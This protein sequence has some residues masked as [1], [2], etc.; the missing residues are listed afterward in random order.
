M[1][2]RESQGSGE[3][4]RRQI[5]LEQ[6]HGDERIEEAARRAWSQK[7]DVERALAAALGG[8]PEIKAAEK[9][10]YLGTFEERVVAFY[11]LDE[12]KEPGFF[13]R[14]KSDLQDPRAYRLRISAE[15]DMPKAIKYIQAA[16]ALGLKFDRVDDPRFTGDVALVIES[17]PGD[18]S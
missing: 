15:V 18:V 2:G 4:K 3:K 13:D 17:E 10:R 9:R 14:L 16:K 1:T 11:R 7:S 8:P 5:S 6:D 12:L